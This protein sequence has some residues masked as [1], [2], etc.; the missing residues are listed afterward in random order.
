MGFE[1]VTLGK[2]KN[3]VIDLAATPEACIAEAAG[4]GMNPK[5]L[6]AFKDGTKTMVEMAAVSNATGLVPDVPGMH[7]PKVEVEELVTSLHPRRATAAS[8][9]RRGCRRLLHGR[10]RAGRLRRGAQL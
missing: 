4:K 5:M 6:S 7:G 2:G 9:R 3:N 8:S 1:V 10:H